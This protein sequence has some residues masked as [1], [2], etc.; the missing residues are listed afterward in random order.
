MNRKLKLTIIAGAA[1]ASAC[2]GVGKG[3]ETRAE[4]LQSNGLSARSVSVDSLGVLTFVNADTRPHEI[5]SPDCP[6]VE[7]IP[8]QPGEAYDV[9]L[10]R[11]PKLCHFEDLL[12]PRASAYWGIIDVQPVPWN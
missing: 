6:E 4:R 5:Y 8:L 9:V 10:G 1:A 7:S 12:A 11:G 3:P 2:A